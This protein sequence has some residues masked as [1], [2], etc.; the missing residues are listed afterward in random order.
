MSYKCRLCGKNEVE[1]AG[2]IC[3][4]CTAITVQH[5]NSQTD[6]NNKK[7]TIEESWEPIDPFMFEQPNKYDPES[8]PEH[9]ID[10][11]PEKNPDPPLQ[12]ES[13]SAKLDND[14][15]AFASDM[16]H[17]HQIHAKS[18]DDSSG[19]PVDYLTRGF[20]KNIRYNVEKSNAFSR[21]MRSI[22]E[23][24]PFSSDEYTTAFQVFPDFTGT[25]RNRSGTVCEQVIIY[26]KIIQGVLSEN[27]EVE[28]YG[29]RD[30]KNN[31][32]ATFVLNV[33]SGTVCKPEG[34][35][36]AASVRIVSVIAAL[37]IAAILFSGKFMDIL[38]MLLTPVFIFIIIKYFLKD[39]IRSIFRF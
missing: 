24:V 27:N 12:S 18:N 35:V 13:Y 36:S 20:I 37:C 7:K 34:A 23:G 26:G 22:G 9:K 25:S 33:A 4:Y 10:F 1:K 5:P 17:L 16:S 31:I 3:S 11:K 30:S 38:F 15:T 32:V 39:I 21:W 14:T 8:V 19:N 2:D 6:K 28:V 29:Y